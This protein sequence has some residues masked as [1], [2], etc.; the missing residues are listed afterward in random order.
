MM[1]MNV[2]I[3]YVDYMVCV[4]IV[5]VVFCVYVKCYGLDNI[6]KIILNYVF[7]VYVKIM[8]FVLI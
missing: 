3:F 5:K 2:D 8:L 1:L 6:V 4:W 7:M